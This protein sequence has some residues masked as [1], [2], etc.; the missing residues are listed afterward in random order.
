MTHMQ[1]ATSEKPLGSNI[2][3]LGGWRKAGRVAKSCLNFFKIETGVKLRAHFSI[4]T[5]RDQSIRWKELS[6]SLVPKIWPPD[7]SRGQSRTRKVV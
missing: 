2:L 3:L 4:P 6:L 1:G 7:C 5:P